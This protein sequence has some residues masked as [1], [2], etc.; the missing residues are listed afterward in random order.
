MGNRVRIDCKYLFI[1]TKV[2]RGIDSV[3]G[4]LL[5]SLNFHTPKTSL[6]DGK[7]YDR[8]CK[9]N[10][11]H[12]GNSHVHHSHQENSLQVT[13]GRKIALRDFFTV[14]ALS[15]H[16][17]FE[18]LAVGLEAS[19]SHIWILFAGNNGTNKNTA[20]DKEHFR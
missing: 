5:S 7:T 11:H 20:K 1:E 14:L 4:S 9:A 2:L 6:T 3:Q 19:S 12:N 13:N 18:G 8:G 17:V 15:F 10:G 16:A